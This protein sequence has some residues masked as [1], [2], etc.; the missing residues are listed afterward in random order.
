M[1]TASDESP[2]I[3]V[4][5]ITMTRDEAAM[6]PRWVGYYGSQ[7]GNDNLFVIDDNS[8]DG[9]TDQLPCTVLRLPPGPWKANWMQT[10]ID[11]VN[12][13]SRGLLSCFDV[14]VFTDVD[15]F[16]VPDPR[17]HSGLRAF[18]QAR[19]DSDV[20]GALA[21]NV[22]HDPGGEAPLEEDRP[23]LAQRRL[24]AFA[25]GMCKP[26]VKRRPAPWLQGFHGIKA[27]YVI[28]PEL[29]LLH[30]KYADAEALAE[31]ADRRQR[32]FQ[33]ERRGS[34]KS[35]WPLG[36]EALHRQL[37]GWVG[38]VPHGEVPEWSPH[39]FELTEVVREMPSGYFRSS[40]PQLDA[41]SEHP[42]MV[43]PERFRS[44]V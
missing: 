8:V 27:P 29:L 35:T 44:L 38:D 14:V 6:L 12:S 30:L 34:A 36:A 28:D 25:P 31:V 22:L 17:R 42:L 1:S 40:G 33:E 10:R 18:L 37:L 24:V 7:V 16:L 2:A 26:L 9:S 20:V 21:L 39:S 11:L 43:L 5:V 32:I 15:E 4:A 3:R 13:L 23:V 19:A 41:M